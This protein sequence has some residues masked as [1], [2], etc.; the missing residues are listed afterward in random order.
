MKKLTRNLII[1]CRRFAKFDNY[2]IQSTE[3]FLSFEIDFL[4]NNKFDYKINSQ[5]QVGTNQIKEVLMQVPTD[6]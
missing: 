4:T 6:G 1:F 5:Q 2:I 3:Q